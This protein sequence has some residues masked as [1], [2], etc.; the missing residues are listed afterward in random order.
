MRKQN[1]IEVVTSPRSQLELGFDD[2]VDSR[3]HSFPP[4]P[5]LTVLAPS[6]GRH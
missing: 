4:Y 2:P 5:T 6:M 3:T 1:L